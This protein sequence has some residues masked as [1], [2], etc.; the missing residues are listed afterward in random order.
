MKSVLLKSTVVSLVFNVRSKN[1]GII[2]RFSEGGRLV[3]LEM[4]QGDRDAP[5]VKSQLLIAQFLGV[6]TRSPEIVSCGGVGVDVSQ[7]WIDP[8]VV[9]LA[10][11]T[12]S[13]SRV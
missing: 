5:V 13:M 4:M 2:V 8:Q 12:R 9:K 10:C 7:L 11:I 3:D 6:V 1:C